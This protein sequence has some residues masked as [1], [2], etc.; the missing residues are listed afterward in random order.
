MQLSVLKSKLHLAA[1]TRSDLNYHGSLTVD[2]ILLEAVGLLPYEEIVVS[3][4]ATGARATTYTIPG[5][6]GEG[7][8]ELNG[9]MAR[10][11]A[12]GDRVI[13]MAFA[14]MSPEELVGHRP[15]VVA[16]DDRNR[17][18]EWI[19]YPPLSADGPLAEWLVTETA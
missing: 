10:L 12:V 2:P 9:A 11:G 18:V 5:R 14:R 17:I 6:P 3:N 19:D 4:V 15:R 8:I 16:L 7:A 1:V 13:V